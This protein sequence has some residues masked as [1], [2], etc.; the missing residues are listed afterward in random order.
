M[1]GHNRELG[2]ATLSSFPGLNTPREFHSIVQQGGI[3]AAQINP[4]IFFS[5]LYHFEDL[6]NDYPRLRA[7]HKLCGPLANRHDI[8]YAPPRLPT[9]YTFIYHLGISQI[10]F[11]RLFVLGWKCSNLFLGDVSLCLEFFKWYGSHA[12]RLGVVSPFIVTR[13]F[14]LYFL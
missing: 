5:L 2:L 8:D 10:N 9:S 13:L 1:L 7:P 11:Y 12:T 14:I 6:G 3:I 4:I